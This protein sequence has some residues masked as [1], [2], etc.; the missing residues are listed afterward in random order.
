MNISNAELPVL[1]ELWSESPL[2]VGQLIERV[3]ENADWHDNTIKTLLSRLVKKEAVER[4]K[5]GRRFFYKAVVS[6]E[7]VVSKESEGF[8]HK[9]FD[10]EVAPLVAHFADKKKLS[11]QDIKEIEKIL[12]ELKDDS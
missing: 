9:F 11:R 3:Q 7:V 10:G 4:Y 6:R 8:L 12:S 1:E 5:D 2:T